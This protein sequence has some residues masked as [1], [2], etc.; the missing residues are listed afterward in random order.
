MFEEEEEEEEE[1][2][3]N[4]IEGFLL[5]FLDLFRKVFIVSNKK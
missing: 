4:F 1:G 2:E 3:G 5:F